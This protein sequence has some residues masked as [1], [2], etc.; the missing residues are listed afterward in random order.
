MSTVIGA[1]T[2]LRGR[3]H[4]AGDLEIAGHVEGDVS[5]TG[6]VVVEAGGLVGANLNGQRITIRGAVKGDVHG[7]EAIVLEAGA[8]V[9]GDLK[10]PKIAIGAGALVRGLV[11]T[12]GLAPRPGQNLAKPGAAKPVAAPTAA[13]PAATPRQEP[14]RP[15]ATTA[16]ATRPAVV[17][18]A[19]APRAPSP[20]RVY[21]E[22]AAE[23]AEETEPAD[24][25]GETSAGRNE[26]PDPIVPVIRKGAKVVAKT[27]R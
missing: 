24:E 26:P 7:V 1:Q 6:D 15:V 13:R 5:V 12:G 21:E 18:T 8:R 17:A 22:P 2:F 11:Q 25:T 16:A 19:P 4:G 10:A 9:V 27:K 14:A 3:V 23:P 20:V